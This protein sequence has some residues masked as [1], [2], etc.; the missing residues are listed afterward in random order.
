MCKIR[1][2]NVTPKLIKITQLYFRDDEDDSGFMSSGQ[3]YFYTQSP[4]LLICLEYY[5]LAKFRWIN[6]V[7]IVHPVDNDIIIIKQPEDVS[8]RTLSNL[9]S[10]HGVVVKAYKDGK[11]RN[12][13]AD[14]AKEFENESISW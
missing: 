1:L 2:N 9:I 12:Y 3:N 5:R 6:T 13:I 7:E 10:C 4:G 8:F 11:S 14:Y